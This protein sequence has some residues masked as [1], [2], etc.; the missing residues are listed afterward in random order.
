[1]DKLKQNIKAV[2]AQLDVDLKAGDAKAKKLGMLRGE[3][4][5]ARRSLG[6]APLPPEHDI[7]IG[8][9][10]S[11]SPRRILILGESTYGQDPPL[12]SYIPTWIAGAKDYTFSRIFN[13]CS[14]AH[15]STASI[16]Q[17]QAFWD[18]IAFYN[19]L[20]VALPSR[21]TRPTDAQYRASEQALD[22]ML[23]RYTP[24][25]VWILGVGQARF[26]WPIVARHHIP[27]V[28]QRHPT[29]RGLR[30]DNLRD[31]FAILQSL[32]A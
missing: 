13:A 1:M 4:N 24:S 2:H 20:T 5:A 21:E 28:V 19:F 6:A 16:A 17:R 26:S 23:A 27:Y 12:I 31:S 25:G 11:Q 9:S 10:Y 30:A 7:W 32:C 3:L 18:S 14:G 8:S 15:T 29:S 22:E